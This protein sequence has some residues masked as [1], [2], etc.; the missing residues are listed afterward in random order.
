MTSGPNQDEKPPPK[1]QRTARL[2]KELDRIH[3]RVLKSLR[4]SQP[5]AVL[6]SLSLVIAAFAGTASPEAVAFAVAASMAFLA[7]LL[8]TIAVPPGEPAEAS[9]RIQISGAALIAMAIGFILLEQVGVELAGKF[10]VANL[11]VTGIL[12]VFGLLAVLYLVLLANERV[13]RFRREKADVWTIRGRHIKA[14]VWAVYSLGATW[15]F[16]LVLSLASVFVPIWLPLPVLAVFFG[17]GFVLLRTG[18]GL[19]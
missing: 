6:S 11:I 10:Q 16:F 4:D 1:E 8:L 13:A 5:L 14:L 3:L 2:A 15:A 19:R 9:S 18:V 12:A 17:L 7:A